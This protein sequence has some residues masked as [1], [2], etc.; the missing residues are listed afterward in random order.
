MG[1]NLCDVKTGLLGRLPEIG[2]ETDGTESIMHPGLCPHFY[3]TQSFL[4]LRGQFPDP[5]QDGLKG[6]FQNQPERPL[7][8]HTFADVNA[9]PSQIQ[10]QRIMLD[11]WSKTE[12]IREAFSLVVVAYFL[13]LP[14]FAERGRNNSASPGPFFTYPLP[15]P[16]GYED[17]YVLEVHKLFYDLKFQMQSGRLKWLDLSNP[18]NPKMRDDYAGWVR[19]E[20]TKARLYPLWIIYQFKSDGTKNVLCKETVQIEVREYKY[21]TEDFSGHPVKKGE[22]FVNA[23]SGLVTMEPPYK[24]SEEEIADRLKGGGIGTK[25]NAPPAWRRVPEMNYDWSKRYIKPEDR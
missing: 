6:D 25:W 19:P 11:R 10:M 5:Y 14:N 22:Q 3:R 18:E 13:D 24:W 20:D 21:D 2:Y 9:Y 7:I 17:N 8:M 1:E 15:M 12:L 16:P 23:I 4:D